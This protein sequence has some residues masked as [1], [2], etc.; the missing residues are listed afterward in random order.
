MFRLRSLRVY[1]MNFKGA[2]IVSETMDHVSG[3]LRLENMVHCLIRKIN[4]NLV[5][6]R[7]LD[8]DAKIVGNPKLW[9]FDCP[10]SLVA[11]AYWRNV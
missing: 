3:G 11:I 8:G 5:Y 1:A 4:T 2:I 9:G 10:Y 7:D 6:S